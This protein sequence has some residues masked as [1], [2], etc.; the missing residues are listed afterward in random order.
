MQ[1]GDAAKARQ[2]ANG[3]ARQQKK[4][5]HSEAAV[6][7]VDAARAAAPGL[8]LRMSAGDSTSCSPEDS[9]CGNSHMAAADAGTAVL[10]PNLPGCC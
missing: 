8:D 7:D 2:Q 5:R 3:D 6:E 1:A 9:M 4:Q 10:L